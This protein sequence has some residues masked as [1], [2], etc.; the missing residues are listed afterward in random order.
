[1]PVMFVVNVRVCV[2]SEAVILSPLS[3]SR[4]RQFWR[5]QSPLLSEVAASD[6]LSLPVASLRV[7]VKASLIESCITP[8]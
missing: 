8:A 3:M 6:A 2:P 1:M 7:T 5:D 4:P